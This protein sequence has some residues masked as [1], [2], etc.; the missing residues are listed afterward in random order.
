MNATVTVTAA[1]QEA[2]DYPLDSELTGRELRLIHKVS[3][4]RAAEIGEALEHWDHDLIISLALI[5]MHR[6]DE[7]DVS[8]DDLLDLP[9]AAVTIVFG[10]VE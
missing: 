10:D 1:G 4:L 3:G 9:G 7:H 8:E 6:A 2:K 5:A